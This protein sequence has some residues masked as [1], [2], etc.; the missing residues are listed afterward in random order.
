VTTEF[1]GSIT[2]AS[3]ELSKIGTGTLTLS[4][5]SSHDRSGAQAGALRI[6]G[7]HGGSVHVWTGASL[8]G[9]GTIGRYL[10]MEGGT[11][12]PGSSPGRLRV[13]D[14]VRLASAPSVFRFELNGPAITL[15]DQLAV[16]DA[17]EL[18]GISLEVLPGAGIPPGAQFRIIDKLSGPPVASPFVGLPEG[19]TL[20]ANGQ[21]FQITYQGGAGH[22]DVVLTRGASTI[23]FG[24]PH[25][26][27]GLAT[28]MP[29]PL[30]SLIVGNI[31]ASG[32]DGV[33]IPLGEAQGWQSKLTALDPRT[34]RGRLTVRRRQPSPAVGKRSAKGAIAGAFRHSCGAHGTE[35][36]HRAQH[37]EAASASATNHSRVSTA[38]PAG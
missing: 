15:H 17:V 3:G 26:S 37:R 12:E 33:F 11:M 27:L 21:V 36:Q 32:E 14:D 29:G 34:G 4:R 2:G 1:S 10:S 38:S 22:N 16:G 35:L 20:N 7:I 28:L 23:S 24:L 13:N 31:G 19:A 30:S 9:N 25:T 6:D 8:G 5:K 18:A